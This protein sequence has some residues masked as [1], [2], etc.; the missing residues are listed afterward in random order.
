VTGP[1]DLLAPDP[2]GL[3]YQ[4]KA[5][6]R[7]NPQGSARKFVRDWAN[8]AQGL[9]ELEALLDIADAAD[10]YVNW[11]LPRIVPTQDM[12]NV[13]VAGDQLRAALARLAGVREP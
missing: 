2:Y 3:R 11:N 7:V 8:T 6:S 9:D 5:A 12:P 10:A 1:R 13:E 4:V